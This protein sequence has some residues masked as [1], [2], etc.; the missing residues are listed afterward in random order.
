MKTPHIL[1]PISQAIQYAK[2]EVSR[3]VLGPVAPERVKARLEACRGCEHRQVVEGKGEFCGRCGCGQRSRAELT[4]KSR[5]PAATCPI[6]RW[7]K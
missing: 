6:G 4:I 3:V 2:A 7:P 5:M 1:I